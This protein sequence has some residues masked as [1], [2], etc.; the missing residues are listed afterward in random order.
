MRYVL[1]LLFGL[2]T[3]PAF[4]QDITIKQSDFQELNTILQEQIPLKWAQPIIKWANGVMQKNA[5]EKVAGPKPAD[6]PK[7]DTAKPEPKQP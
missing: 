7:P 5:E 4:A 6:P 1:P 3:L 2:F